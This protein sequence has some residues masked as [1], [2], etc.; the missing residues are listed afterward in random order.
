MTQRFIV[1]FL[2]TLGILLANQQVRSQ[3]PGAV[4]A[5]KGLSFGVAT[6]GGEMVSISG[7]MYIGPGDYTIN[8]QWTIYSSN[9]A[10]DPN[11]HI[12]G[13][14]RI[15]F[16]DPFDADAA[17]T[18]ATTYIDGNGSRID[19]MVL[20]GNKQGLTL[21]NIDFPDEL[22]K[23]GFLNKGNVNTLYVN[24]TLD[25]TVAG[26]NIH[27]NG[28]ELRL[29]ASGA[30]NRDDVSRRVVTDNN[31]SSAMVKE[32][33]SNFTFPLGIQEQDNSELNISSSTTQD[34]SAC[35]TNYAAA[36]A[37]G[38]KITAP[39]KGMDR[40]WKILNVGGSTGGA[41]TMTLIHNSS[42]GP[43]FVDGQ[44]FITQGRPDSTWS[45]SPGSGYLTR[46]VHAR[47]GVV[48]ST[49]V[50]TTT[51][52]FSKTSDAEAPLSTTL[53]PFAARYAK[54]AIKEERLISLFPN[55][56]ADKVSITGLKEGDRIAVWSVA[57]SILT[58]T[59]AS[60]GIASV[61]LSVYPGGMY[62]LTVMGEQGF[63]Q[64]L[65]IQKQ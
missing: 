57:G 14:G 41:A 53:L 27:L 12:Q 10:I 65:K 30:I 59:T 23:A 60:N 38:L 58:A 39:D 44:G 2:G 13:I 7:S 31:P 3:V 47:G 62:T 34:I 32:Q 24:N 43:A 63:M 29:G 25:L 42:N 22:T 36:I 33:L 64:S 37:A 19:L 9:V 40:A 52:W 6:G 61:D 17:D 21:A 51:A 28:N 54:S 26:A 35:V 5:Y 11:A 56:T 1:R 49:A 18:P 15:R 50:N 8:G 4:Q 20:Q 16:R 48:F 55:P 46:G 45:S